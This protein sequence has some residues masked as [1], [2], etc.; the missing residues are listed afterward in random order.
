MLKIE[1]FLDCWEANIRDLNINTVLELYNI[2]RYFDAGMR[3]ESWSNDKRA[4]YESKCKLIPGILGRFC[5]TLNDTNFAV[6]CAGVDRNYVDDFWSVVCDYKV[7]QR[8]DSS[9]LENIMGRDESV[10]WHVLRKKTLSTFWGQVIAEQLQRNMRTA[11]ELI[12]HYLMAHEHTE[13]QMFS[14]VEFTQEMRDKVLSDFVDR[15][16]GNINSLRL[17]EQAQSTKEFPVSDRLRLKARKKCDSI[18]ERFFA[19][20]AGMSYGAEVYFKSIPDVSVE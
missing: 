5:S 6:V 15:E 9:T 3:L 13:I 12:S 11:E 1:V 8:I 17:L 20:S 7:Y 4:D 2:K 18:Q 19:D 16:D 10:V 14:P